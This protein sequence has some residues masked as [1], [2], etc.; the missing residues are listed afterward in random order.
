MQPALDV[1]L[2]G[3]GAHR[4]SGSDIRLLPRNAGLL[5]LHCLDAVYVAPGTLTTAGSGE[6]VRALPC[7]PGTDGGELPVGFADAS[8]TRPSRTPRP[9]TP[10]TGP[11]ATPRSNS[12]A[13]LEIVERWFQIVPAMRRCHPGVPP[14][15]TRLRLSLGS[16]HPQHRGSGR[17]RQPTHRD[18]GPWRKRHRVAERA[19]A[20]CGCLERRA[21]L[22]TPSGPSSL[23]R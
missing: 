21:L 20:G 2:A 15:W 22:P 17:R 14:R 6:I 3:F 1:S 12:L 10:T 9:A 13:V 18:G 19:A 23:A 5:W 16:G 7:V 8:W 4:S 11:C